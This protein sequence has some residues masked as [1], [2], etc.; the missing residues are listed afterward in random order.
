MTIPILYPLKYPEN[1]PVF[2]RKYLVVR[3]DGKTHFEMWNGTGWAYNG[4][5]I[6]AYYNEK[7]KQ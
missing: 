7:E 5:C 1:K 6:L 3:K 4:N 2:A